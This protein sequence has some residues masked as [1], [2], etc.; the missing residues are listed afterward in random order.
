MFKARQILSWSA[1]SAK[2]M[3]TCWIR[4][5]GMNGHVHTTLCGD[6]DK[7][8]LSASLEVNHACLQSL[9]C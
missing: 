1:S 6:Q 5:Q 7:T 8:D 2:N 3:L 4:R 9:A